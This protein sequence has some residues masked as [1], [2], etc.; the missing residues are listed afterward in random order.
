M[1]GD[2]GSGSSVQ[3]RIILVNTGAPG[4]GPGL[5]WCPTAGAGPHTLDPD[6]GLDSA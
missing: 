6:P 4:L 5:S 2:H 1:K 3:M